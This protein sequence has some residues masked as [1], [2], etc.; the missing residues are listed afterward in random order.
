MHPLHSFLAETGLVFL[1]QEDGCPGLESNP[2]LYKGSLYENGVVRVSCTGASA[3]SLLLFNFGGLTELPETIGSL[4]SLTE[5]KLLHNGLTELPELIGSLLS[6]ERLYLSYNDLT[7]LPEAI[8][9]LASLLYLDLDENDLTELPEAI[10]KLESLE[11]LYLANNKLEAL[12]EAIGSLL[13]LERLYLSYNDLTELPEA[14]GNL[15]SLLFLK[16]DYNDLTELPEAIGKLASLEYLYLEGNHGL[17]FVPD[18]ANNVGL[19]QIV[20]TQ[21]PAL[22]CLPKLPNG[23]QWSYNG[24]FYADQDIVDNVDV[25]GTLHAAV[26]DNARLLRKLSKMQRA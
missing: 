17:I 26:A 23:E 1:K 21:C 7:E 4:T 6:L 8:G 12:P 20:L 15:A 3:S 24:A 13:S 11:R 16:L 9:N 25:C 10:G 14:I 2:N 22:I 5:V 18:M 19:N